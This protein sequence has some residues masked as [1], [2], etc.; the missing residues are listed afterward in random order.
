ML[1]RLFRAFAAGGTGAK[2]IHVLS[3]TYSLEVSH[4]QQ[5]EMMNRI[6]QNFGETLNEH[7]M[8]VQFLAQFASTIKI[9]HPKARREI[10]KYIRM[11]KGSY[12]RGLASYE[13]PQQELFRVA[14][15]RFGVEPDEI[16]A[17]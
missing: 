5:L 15:E 9:D 2:A 8:A 14:R 10:E 4:P 17:A 12:N 13:G 7:E 16:T 6:A 1:G 11:S 3:K